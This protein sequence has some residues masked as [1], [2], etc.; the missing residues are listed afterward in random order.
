MT[1]TN[2]EILEQLKRAS[3]GLL[4]M[5]ESEYPCAAFL[6]SDIAP[7]TPEKVLQQTNH[8]I[9]TPV[10]IVGVDD[11][12]GVAT[13]PEDWHNEEE[14]E[15]V[16]RFQTLVQ[17]LKENLSNLQVYRLG[18]LAIDVYIIG[19]TPTRNLAGLSTKVVET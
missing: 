3:D 16:K 12:F 5:S 7:A 14:F 19:E 2:S 1:K 8:P 13:T 15:T 17:T 10:E 4:F 9:D 18:D 11:F 6:W